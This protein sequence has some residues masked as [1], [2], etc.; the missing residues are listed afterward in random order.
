M[1]KAFVEMLKSL[2]VC[3]R[4]NTEV[5]DIDRRDNKIMAVMSGEERFEANIFLFQAGKGYS[6]TISNP[7]LKFTR[8]IYLGDIKAG[9]SPYKGSTRIGGTM[10]LSGIN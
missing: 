6:I 4:S 7:N 1:S 5:T 10:E 8:P 2:G 3:L 9:I